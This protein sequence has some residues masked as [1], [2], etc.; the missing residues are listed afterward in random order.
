[1]LHF[2]KKPVIYLHCKYQMTGFYMECNTGLK[3]V[4]WELNLKNTDLPVNYCLVGDMVNYE[5]PQDR[6]VFRLMVGTALSE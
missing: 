3:R 4:K 6:V 2:I 5:V 1:M